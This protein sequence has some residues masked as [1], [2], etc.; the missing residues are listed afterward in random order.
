MGDASAEYINVGSG[1]AHPEGVGEKKKGNLKH[2]FKRIILPLLSLV[3]NAILPMLSIVFYLEIIYEKSADVAVW[4]TLAIDVIRFLVCGYYAVILFCC[5]AADST[6]GLGKR[7]RVYAKVIDK[8]TSVRFI[9][10]IVTTYS[11]IIMST[12]VSPDASTALLAYG[13]DVEGRAKLAG[14]FFAKVALFF[15]QQVIQNLR[16]LEFGVDSWA[17]GGH[18]PE[19]SGDCSLGCTEESDNKFIRSFQDFFDGIF[20]SI[21]MTSICLGLLMLPHLY[22]LSNISGLNGPSYAHGLPVATSVSR[23]VSFPSACSISSSC[24][25]ESYGLQEVKVIK[26]TDI[27]EPIEADFPISDK[28]LFFNY[29]GTEDNTTTFVTLALPFPTPTNISSL[30]MFARVPQVP[31]EA[32]KVCIQAQVFYN[33]PP[34]GK[35]GAQVESIGKFMVGVL[36]TGPGGTCH[37]DTDAEDD[38]MGFFNIILSRNVSGDSAN[39][40]VRGLVSFAQSKVDRGQ[41]SEDASAQG[42]DIFKQKTWILGTN[43]KAFVQEYI[44]KD[45][46]TCFPFAPQAKWMF[47]TGGVGMTT[48]VYAVF[49]IVLPWPRIRLSVSELIRSAFMLPFFFIYIPWHARLTSKERAHAIAQHMAVLLLGLISILVIPPALSLNRNYSVVSSFI[50]QT[51]HVQFEATKTEPLPDPTYFSANAICNGV[52][53]CGV[54]YYFGQALAYV[55]IVG[56]VLFAGGQFAQWSMLFILAFI[57]WVLNRLCGCLKYCCVDLKWLSQLR[58]QGEKLMEE[59]EASDS[60]S[61]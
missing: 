27:P 49:S 23:F 44:D 46:L 47:L 26:K 9:L 59:H 1:A 50:T 18:T 38:P 24:L 58:Q 48:L 55:T 22:F 51:D 54:V 40:Y 4:I 39:E 35:N 21:F 56:F 5:R 19:I 36:P 57:G 11:L 16:G 52:Y 20:A 17:V 3:S 12:K 60:D 31:S 15:G 42:T 25:R 29:Q 61:D 33:N 53:G 43:I 30:G 28:V 10:F 45:C 2:C 6:H 8:K 41:E 13:R 37:V 14:L 7:L 32:F 34:L